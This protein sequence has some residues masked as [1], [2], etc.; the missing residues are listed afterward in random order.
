MEIVG[1]ADSDSSDEE[2]ERLL[3]F[4]G[5]PDETTRLR[6]LEFQATSQTD[7]ERDMMLQGQREAMLRMYQD[8]NSVGDTISPEKKVLHRI[9]GSLPM[10]KHK[11][12]LE[13]DRH[14]RSGR[15]KVTKG[16]KGGKRQSDGSSHRMMGDLLTSYSYASFDEPEDMVEPL[17]PKPRHAEQ[18]SVDFV[19]GMPQ[20]VD[21]MVEDDD[22]PIL[23]CKSHTQWNGNAAASFT[24]MHNI[25]TFPHSHSV[26]QHQVKAQPQIAVQAQVAHAP[27][28]TWAGVAGNNLEGAPLAPVINMNI[29]HS[30]S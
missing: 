17:S 27:M 20:V 4:P 7:L 11:R 25:F 14:S 19:G 21:R 18:S 23:S 5:S 12:F 6:L 28:Q 30:K 2:I 26:P 3:T 24:P 13:K 8:T 15:T 22:D 1:G 29:V 16:G 9:R 10:H